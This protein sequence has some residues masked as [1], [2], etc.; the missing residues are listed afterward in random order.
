MVESYSANLQPAYPLKKGVG[1]LKTMLL[2]LENT[3]F[4]NHLFCQ[5]TTD[6][7]ESENLATL[8][9]YSRAAAQQRPMCIPSKTSTKEKR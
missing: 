3:H 1:V 9:N 4:L 6:K 7:L 2:R 5:C 8:K